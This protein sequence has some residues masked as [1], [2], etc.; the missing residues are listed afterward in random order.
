[1][2]GSLAKLGYVGVVAGAIVFGSVFHVL[3]STSPTVFQACL[4]SGGALTLVTTKTGPLT[5]PGG[6]TLVTWDEQGPAGP[7]GGLTAIQDMTASNTF[8]VPPG[9]KT[10]GVEAWGAGGGGSNFLPFPDCVSGAGGGS[11]GYLR[12]VISVTPGE[13]L[14]IT[15]GAAGAPG[16]AGGASSVARGG[17]ILVSAG[18]GGGGIAT[19]GFAATTGGAGGQVLSA[20]GIVRLGNPG[21]NGQIDNIMCFGT[22]PPFTQ[23]GAAGV[24]IQG[25][26]APLDSGSAGGAAQFFVGAAG[27]GGPGEV[28]VSW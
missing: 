18:G 9:I 28:I 10:L 5:C 11:G 1:M 15:V 26:V 3:G 13:S 4:T 20:G 14:A 23:P 8:V 2:K 25:S 27:S 22:N 6:S 21:G 12:T 24:A 16:T 7:A 17:T 19:P